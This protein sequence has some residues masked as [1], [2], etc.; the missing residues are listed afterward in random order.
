M[1]RLLNCLE[2]A[3]SWEKLQGFN[4]TT[5]MDRLRAGEHSERGAAAVA[6][7]LLQ[8]NAEMHVM[9]EGLKIIKGELH[10]LPFSVC[11]DGC[12]KPLEPGDTVAAISSYNEHAPYFAWEDGFIDVPR[13][14]VERTIDIKP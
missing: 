2:C 4:P 1:K 5:L 13:Q 3:K 10:V 7:E 11:C 14:R 6:F 8:G 12:G 9:G